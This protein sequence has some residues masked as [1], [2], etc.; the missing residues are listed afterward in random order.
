MC[1]WLVIHIKIPQI[2]TPRKLLLCIWSRDGA[3]LE[4]LFIIVQ[5]LEFEN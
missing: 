2:L 1:R 3:H 4:L 5:L